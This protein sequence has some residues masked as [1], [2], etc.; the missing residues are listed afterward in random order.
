MLHSPARDPLT[1]PGQLVEPDEH[2]ARRSLV[3]APPARRERRE[4]VRCAGLGHGAVREPHDQLAGNEVVAEPHCRRQVGGRLADVQEVVRG[5]AERAYRDEVLAAGA[6]RHH[7]GF[8]PRGEV[9]G[10]VHQFALAVEKEQVEVVRHVLAGNQQGQ[11]LARKQPDP[12][13]VELVPVGKRAPLGP[14][15][16]RIDIPAQRHRV[17]NQL[18]T[19]RVI[20]GRVRRQGIVD[21]AVHRRAAGR[22]HRAADGRQAEGRLDLAHAGDGPGDVSRVLQRAAAAGDRVDQVPGIGADG[23]AQRAAVVHLRGRRADAAALT[24]GRGHLVA[25]D[26]ERG[27][28]GARRRD[29]RRG[30]GVAG[31]RAAAAG[32][33]LD[34]VTLRRGDGERGLAALRDPDALRTDRA[35]D[36]CSGGHREGRRATTAAAT[37]GERGQRKHRE[38]RGNQPDRARP[39]FSPRGVHSSPATAC[40]SA[41]SITAAILALILGPE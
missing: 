11:H 4:T 12:E 10:G 35:S 30:V 38:K 29:R 14:R 32:H 39:A 9:H 21:V 19:V 17:G 22:D 24:R 2:V 1:R 7:Q 6:R 36:S 3:P 16:R 34:A 15:A 28:H 26:R 5:A 8:H 40:K 41:A 13:N 20:I 25:V 37:A 27:R 33:T 31:Q 18:G 23:E